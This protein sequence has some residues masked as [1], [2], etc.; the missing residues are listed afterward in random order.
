MGRI[1]CGSSFTITAIAV[2]QLIC[3]RAGYAQTPPAGEPE[4]QVQDSNVAPP[5]VTPPPGPPPV[6]APRPLVGPVVTLRSDTHKAR[7]QTEGP[8]QWRDVCTAPCRIA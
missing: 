7:L 2:A 5:E 8:L 1:R 6:A 3:N 4:V